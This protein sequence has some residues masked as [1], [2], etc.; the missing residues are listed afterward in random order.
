LSIPKG[1]C[2]GRGVKVLQPRKLVLDRL[3][4]HLQLRQREVDFLI[5]RPQTPNLANQLANDANQICVR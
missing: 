2:G 5:L 1:L 4:F 3:M